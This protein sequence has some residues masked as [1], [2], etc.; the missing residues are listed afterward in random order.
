ML[1]K[2]V[3]HFLPDLGSVLNSFPDPRRPKKKYYPK[4]ILLWSGILM[5]LLGLRSRR[6]FR[7][8]SRNQAFAANLNTIASAAVETAPHDDTVAR[9]LE[10][11]VSLPCARLPV[12]IVR[13]LIRMKALDHWRLHGRFLVVLDG[14]G[15]HF[16]RQR[17][18][19]ACLTQKT[20]SGQ[21][22]YFHHVLEAKLVTAN[23]LA[24]SIATEFIEN[25]DPKATKQDCERKA[26]RRLAVTLRRD[27]PQLPIILLGDSAYACQGAFHICRTNRWQFIFTFKSGSMPAM[28]AE[29][30]TLRDLSP[31]NRTQR[32]DGPLVQEFAWVND[33]LYEGHRLSAFECRERD[34]HGQQYFAWLTNIP[35]GC[36]SAVTLA[37]Q[38]G[39]LRW[40]IENEG[41]N[42]Q[43]N[44]G[45]ALEHVYS[46]N[47]IAAKN[48]YFLLQVA[49]AIN[50]LIT[51]GSLLPDFGKLLGSLR[52]YLRRLA[53]SLRQTVIDPAAGDLAAARAMQIRLDSS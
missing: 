24:F 33:L 41:F 2:T 1:L 21:T 35:V 32:R 42:I 28:F 49:H 40:K 15:Q 48:F 50:Q 7:F 43:K 19:P 25:A 39:R 47:P 10:V 52:N 46:E 4:R 27:W 6:Q 8:E 29:F 3:H 17:H 12:H 9:Y 38:G 36:A 53:E 45:Y 51:K 30:Q 31:Q 22:L 11:L 26:F 20:A 23:G 13:R 16:Y 44:H 5:F 14:T 18:C 34:D 37:N